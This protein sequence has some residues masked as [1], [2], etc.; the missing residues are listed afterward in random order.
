M[1]QIDFIRE[2]YHIDMMVNPD[3]LISSE[4]YRYLVEKYTLSNGIFTSH[5]IGLTN[6]K[7]ERNLLSSGKTS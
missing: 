1:S 6:L 2:H 7:P 5:R 3:L 4:I